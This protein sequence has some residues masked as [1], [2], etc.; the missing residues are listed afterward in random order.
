MAK[1]SQSKYIEN[2]RL[3]GVYTNGQIHYLQYVFP[4]IVFAPESFLKYTIDDTLNIRLQ[5]NDHPR[6]P[7]D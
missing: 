5:P 3:D 1:I 4:C 7:M 6:R 2:I